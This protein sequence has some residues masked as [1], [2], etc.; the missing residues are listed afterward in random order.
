[1]RTVVACLGLILAVLDKEGDTSILKT[2]EASYVNGKLVLNG[3][4]DK[5][6]FPLYILL[7]HVEALPEILADALRQWFELLQRQTSA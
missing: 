2:K 1:F 7:S 5:Y 4:L 6:P 3:Y